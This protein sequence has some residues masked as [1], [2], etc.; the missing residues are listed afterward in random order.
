MDLHVYRNSQDRWRHLKAEARTRG[1]VLA[2]N[3][4]TLNELVERLTPDLTTATPGQRLALAGP[5]PGA[6]LE[7]SPWLARASPHHPLPGG[8]GLA[9]KHVSG[10]A[11]FSRY[12]YDAI[13][14]LKASRVRS[15][16]LRDSGAE[17]LADALDRY[18]RALRD[19]GLCDPQD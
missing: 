15:R 17:F 1:A 3:A 11:N 8:E 6:S 5:S 19:T 10:F 16:E 18:D 9:P 13:S 12:L 7:A 14:Q 2:I 4:V